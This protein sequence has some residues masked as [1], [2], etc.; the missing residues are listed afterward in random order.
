MHRYLPNAN[1][2]I[3]QM[4]N[5]PWLYIAM[6]LC[7]LD[8]FGVAYLPLGLLYCI[9]LNL[10]GQ[11]GYYTL[12]QSLVIETSVLH[13]SLCCSLMFFLKCS[14]SGP[15]LGPSCLPSFAVAEPTKWMS[16]N[17]VLCTS[18]V[19]SLGSS[20]YPY[21]AGFLQQVCAWGDLRQL[22]SDPQCSGRPVSCTGWGTSIGA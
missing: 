22:R 11:T 17:P 19:L 10:L 7:L 12:A 15:L 2:A 3:H 4:P 21:R 20:L 16:A 14:E 6:L 1:D 5:A 8:R 18:R 9:S 13:T